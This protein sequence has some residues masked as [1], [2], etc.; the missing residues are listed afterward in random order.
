MFNS[1]SEKLEEH[2]KKKSRSFGRSG[3]VLPLVTICYASGDALST[4]TKSDQRWSTP[5][6][7]IKNGWQGAKVPH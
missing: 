1:K 6:L 4:R 7:L 5:G 2:I 3:K